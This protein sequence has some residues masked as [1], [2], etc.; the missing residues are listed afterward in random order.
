MNY[1]ML[2]DNNLKTISASYAFRKCSETK[3][4]YPINGTLHAPVSVACMLALAGIFGERGDG[5][6]QDG[7]KLFSAPALI[8]LQVAQHAD[9]A[10]G[11]VAGEIPVDE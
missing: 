2:A 3:L 4:D 8:A 9:L 11:C 1:I 7:E 5:F 6:A 10:L